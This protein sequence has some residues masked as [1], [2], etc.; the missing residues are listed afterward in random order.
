MKFF[1]KYGLQ[2]A[3]KDF[4]WFDCENFAESENYIELIEDLSIVSK[5]KFL[6]LNLKIENEGWTETKENYVVEISFN[7]LDDNFKF[8]LLCDEWFDFDLII[9]LNKI[10]NDKGITEQFY[11][12]KTDDQSLLIVFGNFELKEELSKD[13][14]L[15]NSEQLI[16][17]KP[18]NFNI[19][20]LE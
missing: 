7:Y 13:N 8:R 16:S 19:L 4:V 14:I 10:M 15:E 6:P 11:P 1:E 17:E 5:K 9:E 3:G 18:K 20:K 2:E 12:V